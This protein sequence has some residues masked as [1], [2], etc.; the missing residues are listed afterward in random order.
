MILKVHLDHNQ[1]TVHSED[2]VLLP[3]KNQKS[4]ETQLLGRQRLGGRQYESNLGT[5]LARPHVN[6]Q[7]VGTCLES[8]LAGGKGRRTI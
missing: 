6:Q 4:V 7:A 8:Q 2:S 1:L 5:K 3:F